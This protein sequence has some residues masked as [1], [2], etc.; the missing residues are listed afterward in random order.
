MIDKWFKKFIGSW[1][2]ATGGLLY[3]LAYSYPHYAEIV[4][5]IGGTVM[6]GWG[7]NKIYEL[8]VIDER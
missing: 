5:I 1:Y 2:M 6:M 8:I 4:Y 7:V 3:L